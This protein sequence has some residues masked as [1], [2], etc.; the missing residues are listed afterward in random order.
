MCKCALDGD[1]GFCDEIIGTKEYFSAL[2]ANKLVL[3]KSLC[4][5]LDRNSMAAHADVCGTGMTE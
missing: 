3:E 2:H 1:N 4:H 5:T